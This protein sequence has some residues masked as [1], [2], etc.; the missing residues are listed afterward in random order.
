MVCINFCLRDF[1]VAAL[2]VGEDFKASDAAKTNGEEE[3]YRRR[4]KYE[5]PIDLLDLDSCGV[6]GMEWLNG[7]IDWGDERDVSGYTLVYG[8]WKGEG[9]VAVDTITA[10]GTN[11]C[12][13]ATYLSLYDVVGSMRR[14][15]DVGA[16]G[17]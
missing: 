9:E 7:W 4:G 15:N 10:V 16:K 11:G 1:A 6:C 13:V 2:D 17:I 8:W 3:L 5:M 12:C 14:R